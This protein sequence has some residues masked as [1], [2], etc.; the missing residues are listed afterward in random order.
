MI[1][2]RAVLSQDIK[3]VNAWWKAH[4]N[5]PFPTSYMSK[6]GAFA[7]TRELPIACLYFYPTLGSSMAL[8]GFPVTNPEATKEQ[9]SV[10]LDLLYAKIEREAKAL[11]YDRLWTWSGVPPIKSRLGEHQYLEADLNVNIYTKK[12]K[13]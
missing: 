4:H 11:G 13:E 7:Y 3:H 6:Y 5:L 9:R 1:L 2:V 10:A 12:I 8:L